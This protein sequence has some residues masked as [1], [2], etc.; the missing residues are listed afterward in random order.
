M[1]SFSNN[2]LPKPKKSKAKFG[3]DPKIIDEKMIMYALNLLNFRREQVK[4]WNQENNI[5]CI[6]GIII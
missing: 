4:D 3:L 6:D 1:L 2:N 5:I